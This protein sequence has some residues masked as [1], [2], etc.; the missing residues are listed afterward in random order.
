MRLRT[1]LGSGHRGDGRKGGLGRGFAADRWGLCSLCQLSG[2]G[3]IVDP[4][5]ARRRPPPST[6]RTATA[7]ASGP[8][9]LRSTRRA[10]PTAGV[11]GHP[12]CQRYGTGAD[13]LST[14]TTLRHQHMRSS[15][16]AAGGGSVL[17]PVI[18]ATSGCDS[19]MLPGAIRPVDACEPILTEARARD[20]RRS[21]P[22]QRRRM[23]RRGGGRASTR[24]PLSGRWS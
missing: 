17:R 3:N 12:S 5:G 9:N 24:L 22:R 21:R 13:G 6:P 10:S 15:D 2:S 4:P 19:R 14:G 18:G 8:K 11:R 16:R 7:L 1:S 23:D 20:E